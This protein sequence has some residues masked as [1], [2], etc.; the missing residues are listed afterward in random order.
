MAAISDSGNSRPTAAFNSASAFAVPYDRLLAF[1]NVVSRKWGAGSARDMRRL[2]LEPTKEDDSG[3]I[4]VF[5]HPCGKIS[6]SY[7]LLSPAFDDHSSAEV[8]KDNSVKIAS[9]A[10]QVGDS[11]PVRWEQLRVA[12]LGATIANPDWGAVCIAVDRSRHAILLEEHVRPFV[13]RL[14]LELPRGY[15]ESH[16]TRK[17]DFSRELLEETGWACDQQDIKIVGKATPDNGK[18]VE[19]VTYCL[20]VSDYWRTDGELRFEPPIRDSHWVAITD[21]YGAVLGGSSGSIRLGNNLSYPIEDGFTLTGAM[22]A[23]PH[24]LLAFPELKILC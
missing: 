1:C 5:D 19:R 18:L 6:L 4:Y 11:K 7:E 10:L 3:E 23:L 13:S 2:L 9:Y 15:S 22:F 16:G 8:A 21:F 14:S 12:S 20:A 24:I 17:Q